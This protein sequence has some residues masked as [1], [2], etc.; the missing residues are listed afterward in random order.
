MGARRGGGGPRNRER[1]ARKTL[2]SGALTPAVLSNVSAFCFPLWTGVPFSSLRSLGPFVVLFGGSFV[3]PSSPAIRLFLARS[4][5]TQKPDPVPLHNLLFNWAEITCEQ[6]IPLHVHLPAFPRLSSSSL[7]PVATPPPSGYLPPPLSWARSFANSI[8]SDDYP[9]TELQ[10]KEREGPPF[11]TLLKIKHVSGYDG[12]GMEVRGVKWWCTFVYVCV[13]VPPKNVV[14]KKEAERRKSPLAVS[15]GRVEHYFPS[16]V[17]RPR[18]LRPPR[19]GPDLAQQDFSGR[20][21][22]LVPVPVSEAQRSEGEADTHQ[23]AAF[24]TVRWGE[25]AVPF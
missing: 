20:Q 14:P 2:T 17:T 7:T 23:L 6:H 13:C 21:V 4:Y 10:K 15:N 8:I 22:V 12:D 18:H 3:T 24:R 11:Y 19:Q 9:T 25:G 5:R 1:P 16:T